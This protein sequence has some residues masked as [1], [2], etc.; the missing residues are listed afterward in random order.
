MNIENS[1]FIAGNCPSSKNSKIKGRFFSKTVQ[2]Y[3]R[4]YGIKTFSSRRKFVDEYKTILMT[5]PVDKL[6]ELFKGYNYPITVGLHFIRGTRHSWDFHNAC[7]LQFDLWTAFDI[8]EDD[9]MDHV[10]PQCLWINGKHYSY[11]KEKPGVIIK[12]I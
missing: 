6:K 3:L 5:Y 4:S 1:V 9:D 2:K 12:I 11:S 8:I 7:Q 10:I